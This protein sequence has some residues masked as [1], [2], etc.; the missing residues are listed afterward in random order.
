MALTGGISQVQLVATHGPYYWRWLKS[1]PYGAARRIMQGKCRGYSIMEPFFREKYGLEIGGPSPIFSANKLVPVYDRCRKMD[2]S[3]FSRQTLWRLPR[4]SS[5]LGF[6]FASEYTAEASD[7]SQIPDGTY[8]FVLAS[9]V[10]EHV[11]NPLRALEEWRRVLCPGGTM[12]V[13]V[14]DQRGTFDHRRIPTSFEHLENDFQNNTT[15]DDLTHLDDVLALHD[16][17][18]D[19]EAGTALQFRQRCLRNPTFRAMHHHVFVPEVLVRM[20]SRVQM[21]VLSIGIERPFHI[22]G[23]AQ[24]VDAVE[25]EEAELQNLDFIKEAAEWRK[26]DPLKENGARSR[27]G[28]LPVR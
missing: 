15:E 2:N 8:N 23:F 10:L 26:Y 1:L 16:L 17:T 28:N 21:R 24:R 22:I 14:P 11:A 25:S 27:R 18:L 4:P 6:S 19:P 5:E 3:N 12:L 7:L 20:F 9:H 13:I